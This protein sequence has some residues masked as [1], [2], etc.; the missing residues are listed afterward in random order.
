MMSAASCDSSTGELTH[1][2]NPSSA[3]ATSPLVRSLMIETPRSGVSGT[4]GACRAR[5]VYRKPAS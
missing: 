2:A 5:R 3:M 1:P 4:R